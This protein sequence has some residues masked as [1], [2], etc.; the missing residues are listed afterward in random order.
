[1]N[2]VLLS[3]EVMVY[4][5]SESLLY[6][7]LLL[8][9][10]VS[11]R[12]LKL[13]DFEAF[14]TQQFRL[15]TQSYL[16]ATILLFM[17]VIK[18]GLLPYFV[19]TLDTLSDIVPG[20]MCGAGVIKANSY[21]NPLLL[22]KSI[23][24]VLLGIWVTLHQLDLEKKNYPYFRIKTWFFVAIFV[25]LSVEY[26]LDIAYFTQIDIH[27]P[28]T[29]CSVIFG[30]VG[31]ANALPFHLNTLQLLLLFYLSFVLLW[32]LIVS[33]KVVWSLFG[34]LLFAFFAYYSVV[35]FFGTYIYELPTHKCPFCM[36]QSHYYYV[37]YMVWGLLL[38]SVFVNV[39]R[40]VMKVFFHQSVETL[41]R[42]SW[43]LPLLFVLLC[44]LYVGVYYLK[45]GVF[46]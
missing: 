32:V 23:T 44:S 36:L 13:W 25:L 3:H 24:L 26:G 46:L 28:V 16:L 45:N 14:T 1:M 15:E 33:H 31:G 37:G 4:L 17:I 42:L 29:C 40:V 7:L 10:L 39:N 20:A 18:L 11:L 9:F 43:L 41:Q 30:Q 35:Y 34:V 2:E 27:K 5:L 19:Y 21:G 38:G 6:G 8:G 12:L 22:V